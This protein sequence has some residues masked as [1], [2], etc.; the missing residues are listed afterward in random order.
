MTQLISNKQNI[1]VSIATETITTC[2]KTFYGRG[3]DIP[4]GRDSFQDDIIVTDNFRLT[5]VTVT[6]YEFVHTWVGDLV[7]QLRH[8]E[9]ETVVDLFKRPGQPQF[10]ASGYSSNLDGNYSFNDR[11][12]CAFDAIADRNAVIPSGDYTS[13]DS[14]R[15]FFGLSA[16]G[17]WRL[18]INDCAIG[19]SGTLGSWKLDLQ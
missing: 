14:L 2:L 6:L 3:G 12:S 13:S 5:E 9:T 17:T 8:L 18:T 11:N 15:A 10:S 7:V 1:A 16:A 4:D 19:D